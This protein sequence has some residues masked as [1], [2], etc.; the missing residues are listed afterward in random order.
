MKFLYRLYQLF[1]ALPL[2]LCATALTALST[3][4]G[5]YLGKARTWGYYPA[6]LWSR[7]MCWIMLLPVKVEGREL[8][9]KRQSY[10]FVANHQ[11]PYDIFLVY[12]YLGRSF[13]WMMKKSLQNL[14][15][16]GKACESA[17]HIMVDK[18]G[19]KAIHKTYEQARKVLQNGVS[20]TVFPEGARSFTGHMGKFRRGAFQ[21]ADELRL[22]VVPVTIDGS[23]DVLPRQKGVNF[24]TWHRLRL[25]IHAPIVSEEQ[26]P[27]AVQ[28]TLEQS[29]SVIMQDLPAQ[30][31]GF[32]ENPD[33]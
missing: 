32:V 8:L 1:I 30:Y 9:D 3:I 16:I 31:Q 12:G 13:R 24:V 7:F 33:Q 21:L 28:K 2:V 15:L 27:E 14:P 11:G 23:F 25:V 20:L 6:M 17:G 19:P 4:I 22:P 26:G 10:V 5:C 18:S 29:Y